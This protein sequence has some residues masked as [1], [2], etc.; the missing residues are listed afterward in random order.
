MVEL[1]KNETN[2]LLILIVVNPIMKLEFVENLFLK[3]KLK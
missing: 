3:L 1:N 2:V